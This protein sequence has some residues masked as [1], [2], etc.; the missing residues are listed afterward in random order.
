MMLFV[1]WGCQMLGFV[2]LHKY[3]YLL[4]FT[5]CYVLPHFHTSFMVLHRGDKQLDVVYR[6]RMLESWKALHL[7]FQSSGWVRRS[8]YIVCVCV[9]ACI[10][11]CVCDCPC[12]FDLPSPQIP[13]V[14]ENEEKG[15]VFSS[16]YYRVV[17]HQSKDA[18]TGEIFSNQFSSSAFKYSASALKKGVWF[19]HRFLHFKLRP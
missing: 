4:S 11:L 12:L 3:D 9:C 5:D 7:E 2:P 8:V 10:C 6:E 16:S 19:K 17:Q 14:K 1:S 13:E 18:E 15:V